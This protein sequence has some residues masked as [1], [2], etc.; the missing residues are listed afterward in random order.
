MAM[1]RCAV[2]PRSVRWYEVD[3]VESTAAHVAQG[4]SIG[5]SRLGGEVVM[6]LGQS[7][8]N[9]AIGKGG[10]FDP[11]ELIGHHSFGICFH[12]KIAYST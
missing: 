12:S 5:L 3:M 6:T 10:T 7:G 8:L 11:F 9:M 1:W 4:E 2:L